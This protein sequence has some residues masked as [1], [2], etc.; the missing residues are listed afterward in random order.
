MSQGLYRP[1]SRTL[2]PGRRLT[3]R[4]GD[5]M[6][7]PTGY[8]PDMRGERSRDYVSDHDVLAYGGPTT[9][10]HEIVSGYERVD[11]H[12]F[13]QVDATM[14]PAPQTGRLTGRVDPLTDGPAAP[15]LRMLGLFYQRAAGTSNTRFLDVPGRRFPTNGS[16]DGVSW[17]YYQDANAAMAPAPADGSPAPDT[18]RAI[19]PSPTRG[20]TVRPVVSSKEADVRKSVQLRQQKGG[21]QDRLAT[22]TAAGQ[23]YSQRTAHVGQGAATAAR[24]PSRRPRG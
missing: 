22:A 12:P 13:V 1:D 19:P 21:H 10:R 20:W 9:C 15:V 8:Y 3:V 23:T 4:P 16:Q 7:K 18:L 17:A 6:P 5:Q 2:N 14:W 24:V 11:Q